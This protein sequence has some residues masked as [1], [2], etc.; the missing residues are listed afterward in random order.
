MPG[1][2]ND[3]RRVGSQGYMLLSES[4]DQG[5]SGGIRFLEPAAG[6]SSSQSG[7]PKEPVFIPIRSWQSRVDRRTVD[8]TSSVHYTPDDDTVYAAALP[9]ATRMEVRIEGVFRMLNT[10]PTLL[11]A[12]Y[13]GAAFSHVILA[14]DSI[15]KYCEGDF[16]VTNFMASNPIDYAVTY[17]A[18]LVSYGVINPFPDPNWGE[19]GLGL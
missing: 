13:D 3:D 2:F 11:A 17:T 19:Q 1:L 16:L 12:L 8:V 14:F 15:Y 7:Q 10:P 18:L 4:L 6:R 9:T 5:A